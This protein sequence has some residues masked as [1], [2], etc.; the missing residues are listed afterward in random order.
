MPAEPQPVF[1][2]ISAA[3]IFLVLRIEPGGEDGSRDVLDN[4]GGLVRS[5]GFRVPDGG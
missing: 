5:V 3:A 4:L 2:P 1:A